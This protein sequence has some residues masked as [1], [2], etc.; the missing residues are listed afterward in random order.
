MS[1]LA[2]ICIFLKNPN[3]Y[4]LNFDMKNSLYNMYLTKTVT[5]QLKW[6]C[7]NYKTVYY[8]FIAFTPC[9]LAYHRCCWNVRQ[10]GSDKVITPNISIGLRAQIHTTNKV[11][12][13]KTRYIWKFKST[14]INHTT[15][16]L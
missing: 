10:F 3:Y 1:S 7:Y 8:R 4:T 11:A 15:G 2:F 16:M 12:I 5:C 13:S 14:K 6:N 9:M